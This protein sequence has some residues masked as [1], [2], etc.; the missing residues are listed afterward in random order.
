LH[1]ILQHNSPGGI[2]PATHPKKNVIAN[3]NTICEIDGYA[4]R[5]LK[6]FS[7][8]SERRPQ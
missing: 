5:D 3:F 2:Q 7:A 6:I 1:F 8:P 4:T